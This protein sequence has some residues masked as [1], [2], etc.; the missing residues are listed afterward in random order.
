MCY[1]GY[2]LCV[3]GEQLLRGPC[4]DGKAHL[5]GNTMICNFGCRFCVQNAASES[6]VISFRG[7]GTTERD[8][9]SLSHRVCFL[10]DTH[11]RAFQAKHVIV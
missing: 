8:T 3:V 6:Q 7:G 1:L 5:N 4:L 9:C 11:E 10:R 2:C